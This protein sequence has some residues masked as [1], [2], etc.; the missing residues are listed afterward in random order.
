MK[1]FWLSNYKSIAVRGLGAA[2]VGGLMVFIPDVTLESFVM[3]V[4]GLVIAVG[5]FALFQASQSEISKERRMFRNAEG[6]FNLILGA[7]LLFFPNLF[8]NIFVVVVGI[9]FLLLGIL[10]LSGALG[11]KIPLRL[12]W[13]YYASSGL[14]LISGIILLTNPFESAVTILRFLGIILMIYGI[15]ESIMAYRIKKVGQYDK[16]GNLTD[17]ISF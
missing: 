11:F 2:V 7:I 5:A 6:I 12:A 1:N 3:V 13:F 10:Q 9:F 17:E 15:S 4:G 16:S 8:I 14:L